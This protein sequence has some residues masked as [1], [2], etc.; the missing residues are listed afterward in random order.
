MRAILFVIAI[1]VP[2]LAALR[3]QDTTSG[4]APTAGAERVRLNFPPP[5]V[6][7][8]ISGGSLL[9]AGDPYNFSD[10]GIRV[11]Q[12]A[13][14]IARADVVVGV[15]GPISLRGSV[16][17]ARQ[18]WE[19]SRCWYEGCAQ[20]RDFGQYSDVQLRFYEIGTRVSLLRSE[21]WPPDQLY[22]DLMAG[23]VEQGLK[24]RMWP[25]LSPRTAANGSGAIGLGGSY[26]L[27]LGLAL[28]LEVED[29]LARYT[30]IQSGT[31]RRLSHSL[32]VTAGVTLQRF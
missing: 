17:I 7:F 2:G 10:P 8:T 9:P 3:A 16:A 29:K 25:D 31:T 27:P 12:K 30:P 21:N 5:R 24:G 23:R 11:H 18:S 15:L 22:V 19:L 13:G 26:A 32:A 28:A 1:L 14:P 20:L 4:A 6:S